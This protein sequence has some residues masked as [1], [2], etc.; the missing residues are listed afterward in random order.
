MSRII[1]RL[2]KS[3]FILK[4]DEI[5]YIESENNYIRIHSGDKSY[6]LKKSLRDMWKE[7]DSNRF[8]RIDR[9]KIVN[10]DRLKEMKEIE[11]YTF[12]II[13]DT[14]TSWTLGRRSKENLL[15]AIR[16]SG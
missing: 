14:G 7:L 12:R 5:D 16:I 13:L 2:G 1:A 3:T 11:N 10:I 8:I 15:K 9:S 4:G 6:L